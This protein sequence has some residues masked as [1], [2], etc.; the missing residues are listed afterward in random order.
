[1][2]SASET[3]GAASRYR[4]VQQHFPA[5]L[6][7]IRDE[8][9]ELPRG[10]ATIRD[11]VFREVL[12]ESGDDT[13]DVAVRRDVEIRLIKNSFRSHEAAS[14]PCPVRTRTAVCVLSS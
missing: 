7:L 13:D 5:M 4:S 2:A 11:Y 1:V 12:T 10:C 8:Q 14:L 6:W 3:K 9:F